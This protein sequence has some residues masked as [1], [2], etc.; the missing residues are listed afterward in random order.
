MLLANTNCL[1]FLYTNI[2]GRL[3]KPSEENF[4][5]KNFTDLFTIIHNLLKRLEAEAYDKRIF[6]S[7][8][9]KII[10]ELAL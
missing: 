10:K 4:T 7:P 5:L 3:H 8:E 6:N 1:W 2:R 9:I